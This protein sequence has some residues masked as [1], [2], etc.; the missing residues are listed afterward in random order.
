MYGGEGHQ[1]CSEEESAGR[2]REGSLRGG[3][4]RNGC[5]PCDQA[6]EL[7]V[8]LNRM[9]DLCLGFAIYKM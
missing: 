5:S 2:D 4:G 7:C 1:I 9:L 6:D 3:K 8:R